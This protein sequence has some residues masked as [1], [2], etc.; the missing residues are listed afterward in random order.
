[1]QRKLRVTFQFGGCAPGTNG[2]LIP[3]VWRFRLSHVSKATAPSFCSASCPS[4]WLDCWLDF[5]LVV[6]KQA[7]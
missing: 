1:M 3:I 5:S 6:R 4:P 7:K 2:G